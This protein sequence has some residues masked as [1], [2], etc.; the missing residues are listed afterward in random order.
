MDPTAAWC[1]VCVHLLKEERAERRRPHGWYQTGWDQALESDSEGHHLTWAPWALKSP[2]AKAQPR[3]RLDPQPGPSLYTLRALHI[4]RY[5]V[6]IEM[7]KHRRGPGVV[8]D[9]K[10]H[11]SYS[12]QRLHA[13][14]R[15]FTSHE[16]TCPRGHGHDIT[17]L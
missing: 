1:R 15:A 5:L 2:K 13:H 7:V 14:G 17:V 10:G 12:V 8:T 16:G 11:A 3:T 6:R 4:S 9:K